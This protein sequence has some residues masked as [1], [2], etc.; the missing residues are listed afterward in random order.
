MPTV[1]RTF[2]AGTI[3]PSTLTVTDPFSF[4]EELHRTGTPSGNMDSNSSQGSFPDPDFETPHYNYVSLLGLLPELKPQEPQGSYVVGQ[5]P[6]AYPF[7]R[8]VY[9]HRGF[10]IWER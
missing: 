9:F 5:P 2:A 4:T 3:N 10:D 7:M 6:M 8:D 1:P